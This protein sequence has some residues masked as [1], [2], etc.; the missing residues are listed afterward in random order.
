M[1]WLLVLALLLISAAIVHAGELPMIEVPDP[2]AEPEPDFAAP[3]QPTLSAGTGN[4]TRHFPPFQLGFTAFDSLSQRFIVFAA[5][6]GS[7]PGETWFV[8][9]ARR[10]A[11][12]RIV[13]GGEP[14]PY[15]TA[16]AAHFDPARRWLV[17]IANDNRTRTRPIMG[18]WALDVDRPEQWARIALH[19]PAPAARVGSISVLDATRGH[20]LLYSGWHVSEPDLWRLDLSATP[21][22]WSR[23]EP[24]NSPPHI[25][26]SAALVFDS[27]HDRMLMLGGFVREV[28]DD[29]GASEYPTEEVWALRFAPTLAWERMEPTG[30]G[31]SW[32]NYSTGVVLD[33]HRDRVLLLRA[34]RT[35]PAPIL[36]LSLG[37]DPAW[38]RIPTIGPQ[39]SSNRLRSVALLPD[40]EEI[41][42][43]HSSFEIWRLRLGDPAVWSFDGLDVPPYWSRNT[44]VIDPVDGGLVVLTGGLDVWRR[45]A[46]TEV[47]KLSTAPTPTWS[48]VPILGEEIPRR[49][50]AAMS[51]D[52]RRDRFVV[53]GGSLDE[54]GDLRIH[55]DV[56]ELRLRPAPRWTRIV[57][58]NDM[59]PDWL[60]F[61]MTYDPVRDR[62]ILQGGW[63]RNSPG[64]RSEFT[65][66]AW[67]LEF[68]PGIRWQRL[69]APGRSPVPRADHQ[70]VFDI[71]RDRLLIFGG[72]PPRNAAGYGPWRRDLWALDLGSPARWDSVPATSAPPSQT[73]PG[74]L[75][76]DRSRDRVRVL[77]AGAKAAE[78]WELSDSPGEVFWTR[79][80]TMGADPRRRYLTNAVA[81]YDARRDRILFSPDRLD[82]VWV[83]DWGEPEIPVE[84][85]IKVAGAAHRE[86]PAR[87][88]VTLL[89]S[90]AFDPRIEDIPTLR[91]CGNP[92]SD[93]PTVRERLRDVN[94]D[95]RADLVL[96][97]DVSGEWWENRRTAI[98]VSGRTQ[99]GARIFGWRTLPSRN[100]PS[101]TMEFESLTSLSQA[102]PR[103][104]FERVWDGPGLGIG[105][106]QCRYRLEGSTPGFVDL[107]T[108]AGRRISRTVLEPTGG[109]WRRVELG[110][111]SGLGS[112]VYFLRWRAGIGERSEKIV[113]LK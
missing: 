113:L 45:P 75:L 84:L 105:R 33:F 111:A 56:W 46:S 61:S 91:L 5:S 110:Q 16:Q 37:D 1:P 64:G 109:G 58:E 23:L 85:Q 6:P 39:P 59:P 51:H 14:P 38:T 22:V 42:G 41:I 112:G 106:S 10:T 20:L 32:I 94:H 79:L 28:F 49:E 54:E 43:I 11:P 95:G 72:S 53:V 31:P 9:P 96:E 12:V 99:R 21:A 92:I 60:R 25:R 98:T 4:W 70:A 29:G 52:S 83:L 80:E 97:I 87:F 62:M 24:G 77:V 35:D 66:E 67:A 36:C 27:R 76:Y 102:I 8:D 82:D 108:P 63:R 107:V 30:E 17:V 88:Q 3:T 40:R 50:G 65:N 93:L 73:N 34:M 100:D 90:E 19:G 48:R 15:G 57:P 89:A 103:Q 71:V 2:T 86:E 7:E 26:Y 47:W 81:D 74:L 101:A 44:G 78:I 18:A 69:E 104:P 68:S 13:P 55:A